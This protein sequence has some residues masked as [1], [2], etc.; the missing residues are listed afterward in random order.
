MA[1]VAERHGGGFKLK[2]L[3]YIFNRMPILALNGS[4]AGVPLQHDDSILLF[5]DYETLAQG[6]LQVLDDYDRLNQLQ[7]RAYAVCRDQFN[8]SSRGESL[9]AAIAVA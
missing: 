4:V 6:T 3:D 1:L 5:E 7:D 2:V 9:L 8:W